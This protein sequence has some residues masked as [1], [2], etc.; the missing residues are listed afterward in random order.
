[1]CFTKCRSKDQTNIESCIKKGIW[2]F[3]QN[4]TYESK[5][6]TESVASRVNNERLRCGLA[7]HRW[8]LR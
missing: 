7:G 6:Y 4:N 8:K 2:Y 1:M 5:M 3:C